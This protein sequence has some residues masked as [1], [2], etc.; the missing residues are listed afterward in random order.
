M[1]IQVGF[2]RHKGFAPLSWLIMLIERTNFSHAYIKI[3]SESLNRS[4]IY[5]ANNSGVW[6]I[7]EPSF[8]NKN[9]EVETY[10]FEIS[11]TQKTKLLQFC[12]DNSGKSYGRLQLIGMSIVKLIKFL[13]NKDIR[14]P[15]SNGSTLYVCSELV[16]K[17]LEEI[18]NLNV[19]KQDNIGIF[20]LEKL[21]K[22]LNK[23]IQHEI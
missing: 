9:I 10:E 23:G 12:V 5:Q 3:Y 18:T 22:S 7:G 6:F 11:S 16:L 8:L 1:T 13:F 17:A 4:L 21:V 20:D 15:F 19:Q 14:N 2:S